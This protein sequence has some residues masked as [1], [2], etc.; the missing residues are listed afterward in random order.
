MEE[1]RQETIEEEAYPYGR[2]LV[3]WEIDEYPNHQRSRRWYIGMGSL[4]ALMFI[5]A[6]FTANFLFA[7]ILLMFA[8]ITVISEYKT[9]DKVP[10]VITT[11]GLIV[12]D[13]YYEFQAIKTF[14]ILYDP[15]EV[16]NL[17][18]DFDSYL[19]P[20]LTVPLEEVDPN[21][22]REILLPFI[23]EDVERDDETFG[24]ILRRVYKL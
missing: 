18:L 6:I 23:I 9:P 20:L 19:R 13:T 11:T 12:G 4:G 7:V 5:Y 15:P 21:I 22:V 10:V 8:I 16:K 14:A 1:V 17:Y 3:Q 2:G 24:D